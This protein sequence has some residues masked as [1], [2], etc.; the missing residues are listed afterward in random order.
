[1][2]GMN[3]F[4]QQMRQMFGN[5]DIIKDAKFTGRTML[6]KLDDELRVKLQFVST[7]ISKQYDA[8]QVSIINRTDGVVDKETIRFGDIIGQ[9]NTN[10]TGNVNPYM[11]EES[12]S[13][14]YWYTPVSI[15]EKA[16]IADAVLDYVGMYQ[17]EDMS[18]SQL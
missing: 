17:D 9:K 2:A 10:I 11:W 6:G 12:I 15:S 5:S 7:F 18:M 3:F 4:E 14:A 16:Q 13:K 1:M 8:I